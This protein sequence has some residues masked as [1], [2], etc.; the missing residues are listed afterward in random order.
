MSLGAAP[1]AGRRA[2]RIL[3]FSSLFPSSVRPQHGIFVLTRLRE[4]LGSGQVQATV[5]APVPWFASRHPRFGDYAKFA[6]TPKHETL[7]ALPGVAIHHPRY[8][9]PPAIGMN[10]QAIAMA[11]AALP[12]LR[13]LHREQPFD[14]IDA[15]YLYPDGVAAVWLAKQLGL[16]VAMTARGTD[17]NVLPHHRIPG[18][19]IRWALREADA[20]IGVADALT[21]KM[22][23]LG[24]PAATTQTVRN[25]VDLLRFQIRD[26]IA[27][28]K[29]W[30]LPMD[31]PVLA[32]VGNLLEAKGQHLIVQAL[33]QRPDWHLLLAG[34]GP[35]RNALQ[36]LI[37]TYQLDN[38]VKM[39]GSVDQTT[40]ND[41]YSA[42]DV[43]IL[44]SAREGWPNVLLESMACGTPAIATQVGGTAEIIREPRAG[45][46]MAERSTA[47]LLSAVDAMLADKPQREHVRDYASGFG[48]QTTTDAQ[49]RL[50]RQLIEA[51]R[52]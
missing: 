11:A 45:R 46:L 35:N 26:R 5:V 27:A 21:Q 41:V 40:L 33:T 34:D 30:A 3:L 8:L 4:L 36:A 14:L 22:V 16:P 51:R 23:E 49:L 37:G 10:V 9:M 17:V 48:W 1:A 12:L 2:I 44:A 52:L 7:A 28:R 31:K 39:L 13:R 6:A 19:M 47:A 43:S 50:F 20:C 42:A 24:A 18:R 15:H 25:G 29:H 32:A 38:R